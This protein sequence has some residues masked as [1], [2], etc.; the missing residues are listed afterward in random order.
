MIVYFINNIC[1][2]L[3]KILFKS[4]YDAIWYNEHL[5][6]LYTNFFPISVQYNKLLLYIA[7]LGLHCLICF[8]GQISNNS[9]YRKKFKYFVKFI[10]M[11]IRT[12]L[13]KMEVYAQPV[14]NLWLRPLK[15]RYFDVALT[16][17][18]IFSAKKILSQNG[19]HFLIMINCIH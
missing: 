5:D 11:K 10:L 3:I 2:T 16:L 13:S 15:S 17:R 12:N 6:I 1:W 4:K 18:R 9:N 7:D 14:Q 19:F 8:V